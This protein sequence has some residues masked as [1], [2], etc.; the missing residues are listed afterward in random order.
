MLLSAGKDSVLIV[1]FLEQDEF[2]KLKLQSQRV[3]KG[4]KGSVDCVAASRKH[5]YAVSGGSDGVVRYWDLNSGKSL[6]LHHFDG[7]V[8]GLSLDHSEQFVLVT[9]RKGLAILEVNNP[10]RYQARLLFSVPQSAHEVDKFQA[11]YLQLI[12]SAAAKQHQKNFIQAS[13]KLEQARTIPGY[14]QDKKAYNDWTSLY[15]KLPRLALKNA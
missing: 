2:K 3:L 9:S 7:P 8:L 10:Y 12:K 5:F 14:E 13:R 15:Q 11:Q 4:H 1:W 6:T